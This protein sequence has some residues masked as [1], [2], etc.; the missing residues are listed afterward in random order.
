V[1]H[2]CQCVYSVR[3]SLGNVRAHSQGSLALGIAAVGSVRLALSILGQADFPELSEHLDSATHERLG[4][5]ASGSTVSCSSASS[6]VAEA[7]A[8]TEATSRCNTSSG[9]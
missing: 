5:G 1:L 6:G 8:E 7:S 3:Y 4:V 2:R 9:E